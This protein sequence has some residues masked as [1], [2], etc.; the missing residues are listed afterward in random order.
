[1]ARKTPWPGLLTAA[2]L[3]F[4][5]LG[6]F[7]SLQYAGPEGAVREFILGV[8][9]RDRTAVESHLVQAVDSPTSQFLIERTGMLLASNYRYV[10]GRRTTMQG[11][12]TLLEGAFISP[13]GQPAPLVWVVR[14]E[15]RRWRVDADATLQIV[16]GRPI[17]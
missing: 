11:N 6:T 1:M 7:A 8:G 12:N 10:A 9:R 3:A 13:L 14:R 16:S 15:G 2:L 4:A 17:R 5:T